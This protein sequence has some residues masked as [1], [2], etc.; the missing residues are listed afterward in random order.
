MRKPDENHERVYQ[1]LLQR[2]A[3]MYAVSWAIDGA[4]DVYLAGRVPLS[5]SRAE[6]IDRMLGC[7]LEYADG[8]S[9]RCSNWASALDPA[10][11]GVAGQERPAPGQPRAFRRL[12]TAPARLIPLLF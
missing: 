9:T 1:W 3:R 2:N 10:R 12:R 8:S 6:E 11:M 5:S 7:V 4:G